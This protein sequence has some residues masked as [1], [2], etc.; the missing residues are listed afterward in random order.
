MRFQIANETI[1]FPSS[2]NRLRV[3]AESRIVAGIPESNLLQVTELFGARHAPGAL[4]SRQIQIRSIQKAN[5]PDQCG[6]PYPLFWKKSSPKV[7]HEMD[8]LR[9][10][11][12]GCIVI[13]LENEGAANLE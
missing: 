9:Q 6:G 10:A 12:W 4:D 11:V 8:I 1:S 2:P 3:A 7:R 5:T 13:S